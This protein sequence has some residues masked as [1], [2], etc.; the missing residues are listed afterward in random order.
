MRVQF[1]IALVS[2]VGIGAH[3]TPPSPIPRDL[4]RSAIQGAV[5]VQDFPSAT[6]PNPD[7][8]VVMC[9]LDNPRGLAFNDDA[10]L[11]AEAGRGGLDLGNLDCF[12]GQAGGTRCFGPNGAISRLWNGT[13]ERI[14]TGFPSHA[15]VRGQ[16]AIGPNDIAIVQGQ[17]ARFGLD[18][19][20][21]AP[22]C[23][24]GCAYVV[25]GLQQPP[26]T[27]ERSPLFSNFAKLARMTVAGDWGYIA[28]LG[29]YEA[30]HD[31]DQIFYSPPKLDTNPYGL[32][33]E[34]GGRSV[35]ITDAGANS[36]LRVGAVGEL[37]PLDGMGFSTTAVFAPHPTGADDTVPTSVVAGPDGALYVGELTGFPLIPNISRVYRVG[38]GA[39]PE[40]CLDGFTQIMD[41][42]FDETGDLY[43]LQFTGSLVRVS[44]ATA[45]SRDL[46]ARYAEGVRSV[47]ASGF[48][49]PTA[50]AIGPDGAVYV[51]N[52]GTQPGTGQVVRL[53]R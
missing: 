38:R 4:G 50:I 48:T 37:S 51:S 17:G 3:G 26:A 41:L 40:I 32:L 31:P 12:I 15:N 42:A 24:A 36:L 14:A 6:S 35:L 46:C 13:Q 28:D 21:A 11:V 39:A 16:Q 27:R 53:Q 19:P 33:V 44:P 8:S 34:P 25:I 5:C 29:A 45:P 2:V 49:M 9:G 30:A 7:A 47:V 52:R 43:V 23:A 1:A 18:L 22:E 20:E 10:L